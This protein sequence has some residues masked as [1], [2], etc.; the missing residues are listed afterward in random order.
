[1]SRKKAQRKS[2]QQK[3]DQIFFRMEDAIIE[4]Q[5]FFDTATPFEISMA[6]TEAGV[7]TA[8]RSGIDELL[9]QTWKTLRSLP[10]L[11]AQESVKRLMQDLIET[12]ETEIGSKNRSKVS[13]EDRV[14]LI[15]A[16][17]YFTNQWAKANHART[18][19]RL[20]QNLAQNSPH[21]LG[22]ALQA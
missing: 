15:Q 14:F 1:M 11:P 19:A 18:E 2:Y 7:T 6:L 12:W 13:L 8:H 10:N 22:S 3:V 4:A 5:E 16:T 9:D 21:S 17:N 20:R